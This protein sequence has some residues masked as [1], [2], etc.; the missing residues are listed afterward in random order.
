M[1]STLGYA[2]IAALFAG[3]GVA[4]AASDYTVTDL[5]TLGGAVS[6]ATAI[7]S[8]G[9][10]A[11]VSLDADGNSR[12]FTTGNDTLIDLGTLGGLTSYASD[13]NA[14][15]DVVGDSLL[16]SRFY[17]KTRAFLF[18]GN[19]L[20]DL[21]SLIA[22]GSGWTLTNAF[23]INDNGQI[24]GGGTDA[25]GRQ[26]AFILEP[27]AA[28]PENPTAPAFELQPVGTLGGA[29]SVATDINAEGAIVGY[30]QVAPTFSWSLG[31]QWSDARSTPIRAFVYQDGKITNLGTLDDATASNEYRCAPAGYSYAAAIND[32][33]WIVGTSSASG[34]EHAFLYADGEMIDIG[35]LPLPWD[36]SAI[37]PLPGV[38]VDPSTL[39]KAPRAKA[40]QARIAKHRGREED[41]TEWED[42]D[43]EISDCWFVPALN[44]HASAINASGQVVG[45]ADYLASWDA[46]PEPHAFLY[47]TD[48]TLY[49]LNELIPADSGWTLNSALGIS[50]DGRIVG[51]GTA[52]DGE[53]RAFLLTPS[54]VPVVIVTTTT[55]TATGSDLFLVK[56]ITRGKVSKVTWRSAS[57]GRSQAAIGTR[58][59]QFRAKLKPGRNVI[60]IQAQGNRA[61]SK[62]KK[63][64]IVRR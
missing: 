8:T 35:T 29:T 47:D 33:G 9:Q 59:W 3:G 30:S 23:G 20:S 53:T 1:K 24:V 12:A 56:G 44:S 32:N 7:S 57:K 62:P 42:D 11:G 55:P 48:G 2:A 54:P 58:R 49:D 34:A 27:L 25:S 31:P 4:S 18:R 19:T 39:E 6:A 22:P 63:V 37:T 41:E 36:D 28:I 16:K 43:Y 26:R 61:K 50:D 17:K 10:I 46:Q 45:D 13:L 40:T 51:Y 5:G 38:D 21:N 15:G 60:T 52:P 14:A 64:I